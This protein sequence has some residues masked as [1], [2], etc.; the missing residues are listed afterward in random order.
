[1]K[2]SARTE[3]IVRLLPPPPAPEGRGAGFGRADPADLLARLDQ[4]LVWSDTHLFHDAVVEYHGRP[5]DHTER[6]LAAWK[7]V[8][9]TQFLLHLGDIAHGISAQD[10]EYRLPRRLPGRCY[11]LLGN[12]DTRDRLEIFAARGV[13]FLDPFAIEYRG[14][15]FVFTHE[16]LD[17]VPAGAY[18]VHGHIHS[19]PSP[20]ARHINLSVELL[21]YRPVPLIDRLARSWASPPAWRSPPLASNPTRIRPGGRSRMGRNQDAGCVA[22]EPVPQSTH[23]PRR[24]GM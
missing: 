15:P 2:R 5:D 4:T 11:L 18:N 3:G 10:L 6:M 17:E 9:H 16:P 13:R 8:G 19:H 7:G 23:E 14:T 1:M 21:D 24:R 12:H 22:A 20:S